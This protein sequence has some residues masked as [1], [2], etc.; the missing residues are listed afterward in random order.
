MK[1]RKRFAI[2]ATCS[3][4]V[5]SVP[6]FA[7]F[8]G[9]G[10]FKKVIDAAKGQTPSPPTAPTNSPSSSS[11]PPQENS[12]AMIA[13]WS[14]L[15]GA[16]RGGR[17]P[18]D[19]DD[20]PIACNDRDALT[21]R[22]ERNGWCLGGG[23]PDWSGDDK[24][25][26]CTVAAAPAKP[27]DI[28]KGQWVPVAESC[29]PKGMISNNF[30]EIDIDDQSDEPFPNSEYLSGALYTCTFPKRGVINGSSY[31]GLM[32][33]AHE[34]YEGKPMV[35]LKITEDGRLHHSYPAYRISF[36]A[37][38][39]IMEAANDTYKRCPRPLQ[40]SEEF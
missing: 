35:T 32:N 6:L 14:D 12:S 2:L 13:R 16:C 22:L 29:A 8:G 18:K 28:L 3:A 34:G 24:W 31:S 30:I 23:D 37:D 15:H 4:L 17:G 11:A 39:Q 33:C 20:Y 19:A 27:R 5:V 10:T 25:Q 21:D 26:R 9:L 38:E 1:V 7:Q 36:D 40:R